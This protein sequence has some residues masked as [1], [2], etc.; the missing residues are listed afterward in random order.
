[1]ME[2]MVVTAVAMEAVEEIEMVQEMEETVR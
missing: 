1:M 2:A